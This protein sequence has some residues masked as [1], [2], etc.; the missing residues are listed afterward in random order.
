MR[1]SSLLALLACLLA[2]SGCRSGQDRRGVT[3]REAAPPPRP[4]S[5]D[6]RELMLRM[7]RSTAELRR[8]A[9]VVGMEAPARLVERLAA[10]L[11]ASGPG[12]G[13]DK[14]R[15]ALRERASR[16]AG[17]R[18][19]R[20]DYQRLLEACTGCHHEAAPASLPR[21]ERLRLR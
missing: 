20:S 3:R 14:W 8:R 15:G 1:T 13:W 4:T 6:V 12:P 17:S 16:L 9:G 5:V 10:E 11:P 7:E 18:A 2:G 21:L 19:P